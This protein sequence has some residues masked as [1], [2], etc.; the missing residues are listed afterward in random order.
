MENI[1]CPEITSKK[2][3]RFLRGPRVP[4]MLAA[5]LLWTVIDYHLLG[6]GKTKGTSHQ[7]C[8]NPLHNCAYKCHFIGN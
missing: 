4:I 1:S 2:S 8:S 7:D 3:S 5:F 6:A